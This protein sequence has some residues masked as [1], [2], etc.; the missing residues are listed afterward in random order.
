MD[1]SNIA[2]AVSAKAEMKTVDGSLQLPATLEPSREA[3]IAAEI[4]EGSPVFVEPGSR[5]AEGQVV[6]FIN[7]QK[8]QLTVQDAQEALNKA[9]KDYQLQKNSMNALGVKM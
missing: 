5:V 7:I 1:R 6:G 8:Q 9:E 2:M 3:D 4:A